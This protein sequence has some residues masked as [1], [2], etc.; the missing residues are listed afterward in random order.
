M[1]QAGSCYGQD[2][3]QTLMPPSQDISFPDVQ[4]EKPQLFA[5]SQRIRQLAPN[6]HEIWLQLFASW[7]SISHPLPPESPAWQATVQ[8]LAPRQSTLQVAFEPQVASQLFASRQSKLHVLL[9]PQVASQLP[10][11]RHAKSQ[12]QLDGQLVN[13][14]FWSAAQKA[15]EQMPA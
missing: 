10:A 5:P 14:Q 2:R 1:V 15:N 6:E 9:L 7:Q 13:V 12:A 11:S 3:P 8:P 4:L